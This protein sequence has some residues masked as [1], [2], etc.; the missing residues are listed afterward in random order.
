MFNRKVREVLP[1]SGMTTGTPSKSESGA[2]PV[3]MLFMLLILSLSA[4]GV[5]YGLWSKTLTIGVTVNTGDVNAEF[6]QAFTDDDNVVNDVSL[7]AEDTGLCAF[8]LVDDDGDGEIDEDPIDGEDNDDD[9]TVDEDPEGKLTSC[10]PDGSGENAPRKDMDIGQ[11]LAKTADEDPDQ[12]G[13]QNAEVEILDGYPSYFC[14]AWFH[15]HNNGSIPVKVLKIDIIDDQGTIIIEDA[16][17]STIYELDLTGPEGEPDGEPDLN[18]HITD[19][20]LGQQIDPS[21]EVLMDIDMH[22]KEE[23]PSDSTFSFEVRIELA[24]WNEVP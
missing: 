1:M 2:P 13:D 22:V 20:E 14:T 5:A 23:A 6:T 21:Q 24:Q 15:I 4:L 8:P 12:V 11:C 7:D 19:I 10:D 3:G 17:P 18:L 16:Q 9:G